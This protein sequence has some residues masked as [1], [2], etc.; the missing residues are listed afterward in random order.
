[1]T[2]SKPLHDEQSTNFLLYTTPSGDIN[3]QI[4]IQWQTGRL[5]QKRMAELF[6]VDS[7]TISYH[8]TNIYKEH[9]LDENATTEEISVVQT[10]W[11]REVQRVVK[12]YN[13]DAVISV[14][15]R[16]NSHQAT[17]FRI[18]ATTILHDYIIKGFTIDDSRL[19]S[20]SKLFG[21]DYFQELLERV[22]SIRSSERRIY[23]KITD[24]FAECSDDYSKDAEITSEF[25]ATVQNKFHYAI[26]HQTWAEIVHSHANH[27][28]PNMWLTTWKNAPQG[29]IL[30][31][32]VTVAKNYLSEEEIKKLERTISSFF[33][34]IENRI[35]QQQSFTM[36][37]FA[38][39]V[40]EF[41]SFNRFEILDSKWSISH[42]QAKI[43]AFE[44]YDTYNKQQVIESDFDRA[45]NNII[46]NIEE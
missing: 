14:W 26:T 46:H 30:K 28:K 38:S 36:E 11:T 35:E 10:E 27:D 18:W 44:E 12:H 5:S 15:Y 20:W 25:Y 41:L 19:K 45:V 1:M 24:I 6:G 7:D 17:Q 22:R 40:N 8:L 4:I 2:Q 3:I 42:D 13:L 21:Q 29:R 32:D 23:Q 37:E 33:D 39:S 34:Y 9:E 31:S 43:K 16:V